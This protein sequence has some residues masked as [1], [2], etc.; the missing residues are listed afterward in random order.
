MDIRALKTF[1]TIVKRGSF[2]RAAEELQYVQSTVTMQIQK[3]ESDL[4]VKLFERGKKGKLTDAGHLLLKEA[5]QILNGVDAL[6][7]TMRDFGEGEAGIIRMGAIEP[8]ASFCLPSLLVPFC[9]ER[10]KVQLSLEVGNTTTISQRV[11]EGELDFGICSIPEATANVSFE[12]WYTEPLG[13]LLPASHHLTK[14]AQIHTNDLAGQRLLLTGRYC[15]Y[16]K[17]LES[18]LMERGTNPYSGIEIGSVEAL[19]QLV[20][21]NLGIAIVPVLAAS[22]PPAGTVFRMME[23]FQPSYTVGLVQRSEE[24]VRGRGVESLVNMLRSQLRGMQP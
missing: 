14:Q 24:Y 8:T 18:F 11:A 15:P 7:M 10:P 23:D 21:N 20:K 6:R 3:L 22:P 19:K 5:A 9:S 4:G 12:A 17:Q 1:Q 2:Q 13:L 16:R